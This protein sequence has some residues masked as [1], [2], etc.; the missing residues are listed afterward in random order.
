MMISDISTTDIV[1]CISPGSDLVPIDIL[2]KIVRCIDDYEGL[3]YGSVMVEYVLREHISNNARAPNN[4]NVAFVDMSQFVEFANNIMQIFESLS[5]DLRSSGHTTNVMQ[6]TSFPSMYSKII[7]KDLG[8]RCISINIIDKTTGSSV[9]INVVCICLNIPNDLNSDGL[10]Q[11]VFDRMLVYPIMCNAYYSHTLYSH[12]AP[13]AHISSYTITDSYERSKIMQY[14][15]MG[16][17]IENIRNDPFERDNN[18]TESTIL[19]SADLSIKDIYTGD[20]PYCDALMNAKRIYNNMGF[21][22]IPLCRTSKKPDGKSPACKDWYNKT[23]KFNFDTSKC[24]NIGIVCGKNSGICCIDVDMKDNGMFYFDK[25]IERYSLPKCPTQQTPNGGR[26]YIFKYN[27]DRMR[28]MRATIK[29]LK[30]N[31]KKIGVDIWIKNC[32]FVVAP[33][34][35]YIVGK[36]Y[37]WITPLTTVADIPE[38]PDW[39]YDA[40]KYKNVSEDGRIIKSEEFKED[41]PNNAYCDIVICDAEAFSWVSIIVL[42]MAMLSIVGIVIMGIML[43]LSMF[44]LKNSSARNSMRSIVLSILRKMIEQLA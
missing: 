35:N 18:G 14:M 25:M 40:Y 4:I 42:A 26:H 43:N 10:V 36:S 6:A 41:V 23:P 1:Q 16:L 29:A 34:V 3:V 28:N 15:N 30:V 33:S 13:N 8:Q 9:H 39:I 27:D 7:F 24:A 22:V 5:S 20:I 2:E 21:A 11:F 37:K 19:S 17:I 38:L 32:Q 12:Y 31:G 44:L